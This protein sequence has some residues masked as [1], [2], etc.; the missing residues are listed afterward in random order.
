M[1]FEHL[2]RCAEAME[3]A[4][5]EVGEEVVRQ[6]DPGDYFY[7]LKAGSAEVRRTHAGAN[8]A[9]IAVLG[10][11]DSFGEE[12]LLKGEPRNATV[13][14]TKPGRLLKLGKQAFDALLKSQ[15]LHE[16][17]SDEARRK[18]DF[19]G[20]VFV[21]C[22]YEEEWEL[23]RLKGARLV[24]LDQIRERL[25]GLDPKREYVVYCR[26]GRRSRAAAF[27]MRQAGL[28]AVSLEGGIA[29]WPYERETGELE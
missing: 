13:H 24:P 14:M 8:P 21:D 25:R 29:A 9:K 15:L 17:S 16:I 6:G 19:R 20:A 5:V 22:R 3:E 7:V 11:G 26:T 2:V 12:A 10:P 28:N 1:A 23:W 27:L 4:E 18:V